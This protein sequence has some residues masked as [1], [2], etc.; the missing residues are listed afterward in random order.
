MFTTSKIARI[1]NIA[2]NTEYLPNTLYK[3]VEGKTIVY[4]YHDGPDTITDL[5]EN[6]VGKIYDY[7]DSSITVQ[8]NKDDTYNLPPKTYYLAIYLKDNDIIHTLLSPIDFIV[9]GALKYNGNSTY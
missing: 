9:K 7:P 4:K 8:F 2:E 3:I 6:N 5:Y 1:D